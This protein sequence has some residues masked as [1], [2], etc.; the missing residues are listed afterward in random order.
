[1]DTL[2]HPHPAIRDAHQKMLDLC[3][4]S[5]ADLMACD[6][7]DG[8]MQ[9]RSTVVNEDPCRNDI[10]IKC[11]NC[12]WWTRHGVPIERD[13]YEMEMAEREQRSV[14]AVNTHA[15]NSAVEERLEALGYIE[16]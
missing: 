8:L 12:L 7:C 13:E 9:V 2:N 6:R 16:R 11:E 1:M 14:D 5:G 10:R 3:D 4:E 15:P